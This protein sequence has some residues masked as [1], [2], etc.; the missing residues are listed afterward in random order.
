[1]KKNNLI[2]LLN[3]NLSLKSSNFF[4]L[5]KLYI[6]YNFIFYIIYWQKI[7]KY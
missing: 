5:K 6:F 2:K 4:L 1:M 7:D 3:K